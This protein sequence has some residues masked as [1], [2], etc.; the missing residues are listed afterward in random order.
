[1]GEGDSSL[2]FAKRPRLPSMPIAGP[3]AV[4][5][6]LRQ[7]APRDSRSMPAGRFAWQGQRGVRAVAPEAIRHL[8]ENPLAE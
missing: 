8:V 1:M 6:W 3:P 4:A 5:G 2:S 7:G